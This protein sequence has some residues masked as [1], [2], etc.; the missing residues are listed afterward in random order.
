MDHRGID[1]RF[2]VGSDAALRHGFCRRNAVRPREWR[3]W[4]HAIRR[5]Y[6]TR[7]VGFNHYGGRG[8]VVAA[9][10]RH[11]FAAFIRDMGPCP[12]GHSLDRIDVDGPYAPD[13]CRWADAK[14]QRVNQRP[15]KRV[16]LPKKTH[17]PHGHAY[18]GDNLYVDKKTG[19]WHCRACQAR[20]RQRRRE[21]KQLQGVNRS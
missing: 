20:H 5:C 4:S 19:Y 21:Q 10:W 1:G 7:A 6:D 18:A 15:F 8:I 11:D 16:P 3:S 13:N 14:T 17:C 2:Q 12:V 9:E